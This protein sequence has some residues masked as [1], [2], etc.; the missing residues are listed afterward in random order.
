MKYGFV[1]SSKEANLGYLL[2]MY[3]GFISVNLEQRPVHALNMKAI[4]YMVMSRLTLSGS[5]RREKK[6]LILSLALFGTRG[7]EPDLRPMTI[8]H[9]L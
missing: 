6:Y 3:G 4:S 5:E 1:F 2:R 8:W 7:A 9:A